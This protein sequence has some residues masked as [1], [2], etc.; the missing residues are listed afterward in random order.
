MKYS[1]AWHKLNKMAQDAWDNLCFCT[2]KEERE[3]WGSLYCF[4][5][6]NLINL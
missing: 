4:F 5:V 6:D 2:E 1:S 3:H